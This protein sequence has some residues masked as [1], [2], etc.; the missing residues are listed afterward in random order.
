MAEAKM[1]SGA[2]GD[3]PVRPPLEI[4]P[5]RLRIRLRIQIGRDDH[6]HDL[7]ALLQANT[8]ELDVVAHIARF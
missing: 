3:M 6:G 1:D 2:E 7:V 4:E 8:L 5:L